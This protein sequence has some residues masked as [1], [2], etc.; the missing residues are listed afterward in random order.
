MPTRIGGAVS[1]AATLAA[2]ASGSGAGAGD[3]GAVPGKRGKG[4]VGA[5][6]A[7]LPGGAIDRITA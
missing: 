2:G 6:V 4:G 3:P 7:R 5:G 1:D